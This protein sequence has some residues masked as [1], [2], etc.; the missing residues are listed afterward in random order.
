MSVKVV[1]EL[2]Y[3]G[4]LI[5][6]WTWAICCIS[7]THQERLKIV[8][9]SMWRPISG[10]AILDA[11]KTVSFYRH[12]F[13]RFLFRDPWKL[14]DPIVMH[15]VDHPKSEI[16]GGIHIVFTDDGPHVKTYGGVDAGDLHLVQHDDEDVPQPVRH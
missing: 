15:A 10:M 9:L 11:E 4:T 8:T 16:V 1:V 14:Y 12:F 7:I 13:A 6:G 3:F 2:V 5:F